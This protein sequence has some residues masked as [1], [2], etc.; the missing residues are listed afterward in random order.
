MD[1]CEM[2]IGDSPSATL[3]GSMKMAMP[4]E[5]KSEARRAEMGWV[6]GERMFSSP[7][8]RG[9]VGAL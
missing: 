3:W 2:I 6:L 5:P 8:A 4:E 7:P 9:S 1:R